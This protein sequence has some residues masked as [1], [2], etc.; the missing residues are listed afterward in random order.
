MEDPFA[1]TDEM[2]QSAAPVDGSAL[3]TFKALMDE[4]LFFD[5]VEAAHLDEAYSMHIDFAIGRTNKSRWV[6]PWERGVM[7]KP[8]LFPKS[9]PSA[10]FK[11]AKNVE[12]K[13][14]DEHA[15][16]SKGNVTS[17]SSKR[18]KTG[19]NLTI[20]WETKLSNNRL[21]AIH[22]WTTVIKCAPLDFGVI[23]LL[24]VAKKAGLDHSTVGQTLENVFAG[25]GTGTLHSRAGPILR[26]IKYWKGRGS[27][28]IPFTEPMVYSFLQDEGEK[29]AATFAR[30]FV[31]AL[32]FTFHIVQSDSA[33]QC[34]QSKRVTGIAT[35]CF[36]K[37][38]A[39]VQKAPLRVEH[40]KALESIVT[41]SKYRLSD[42]VA[43]GFFCYLIYA[44]AR[45]SD[46]QH[47]G[48]MSLDLAT[49]E[50][51]TSGYVEA[52]VTRS[53]SSYTIE[54]KTR[55]LP[56]VA[57]VTGLL[58]EPW[59]IHWFRCIKDSKLQIGS[60]RPLLPAPD[61]SGGWQQLP[62][63]A[64][65]GGAWLRSLL[66]MVCGASDIINSYGTH[67]CKATCLSWLAKGA[68]DLP[69][70]ALLG[71]H[72]VGKASTALI[73]GRDNMAGP[74]RTLEDIVGKVATGAL[75]PDMTR[76][77][78]LSQV[79]GSEK[80]DKQ[81][82][83]KPEEEPISSSEDSADEEA[84]DHDLDE[85]ALNSVAEK[86]SGHIRQEHIDEGFLYRHPISRTIHVLLEEG[87]TKFKC[88]RE[89][90]SSH[91]RL[92]EAPLVMHPACKQ[93][94]PSSNGL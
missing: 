11:S 39:L 16:S 73:Y 38:R 52:S 12:L 32:A 17:I 80:T 26:Y 27:D 64:E 56:M 85:A 72:S 65:S 23:R 81:N 88:G 90:V 40:V 33:K 37:K 5:D 53:K 48:N 79:G 67:S 77:G 92:D 19:S 1:I 41:Q 3:A 57:P 13:T 91:I 9:M 63:T 8:D 21:A 75:R 36:L 43:A 89:V 7:V 59:A 71:Y 24:Y 66:T 69:T 2:I 74:L 18:L 84:P 29:S 20:S 82:L 68:V 61:P 46:G 31:C 86:W 44:R 78:M 14:V 76:S 94:F 55:H 10:A 15:K 50:G 54:R 51:S 60:K 62:I 87:T 30:S 58:Q 25:K 47:S 42:R 4:E 93:C 70:R 83:E 49:E 28:P 45:F 22:K 6:Q 35:K 34:V